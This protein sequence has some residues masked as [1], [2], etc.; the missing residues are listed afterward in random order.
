MTNTS[1]A[2]RNCT[3]ASSTRWHVSGI[4]CPPLLSGACLTKGSEIC[5]ISKG[6]DTVTACGVLQPGETRYIFASNSR[7]EEALEDVKAFVE[8][9]L[10]TLG[11][12]EEADVKEA[13]AKKHS[14]L[15]SEILRKILRFNRPRLVHYIRL[16]A[17]KI[18]ACIESVREGEG[19][20]SIGGM[21]LEIS[22]LPGVL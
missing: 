21:C 3:I 13:E 6:P 5:D 9:I 22:C 1:A 11:E 2:G 20:D 19:G 18:E 7:T 16:M 8:D 4:P 17:Q 10:N 15:F 12:V 14:A